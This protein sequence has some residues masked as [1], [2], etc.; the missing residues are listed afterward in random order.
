[1]MYDYSPTPQNI[2]RAADKAL[3]NVRAVIPEIHQLKR[4]SERI[5][6]PEDA[7]QLHSLLM[8]EGDLVASDSVAGELSVPVEWL[9]TLAA[10]DRAKYIE[11]G[12]W[13]AAEQEQ[14]YIDA[15][16]NK[17]PEAQM[18]IVRRLLRYRGAMSAEQVAERYLWTDETAQDILTKLC[19]QE[20]IVEQGGIYYHGTLYE[21]ARQETIK[22][23]R[24]AHV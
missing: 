15:L 13:I 18:K 22:E 6:M 14:D 23:D 5:K 12:L 7:E 9:E 19:G 2:H 4:V 1:M 3:R 16:E 11:P 20:Q 10:E 21:R 8:I 17:D 24:R